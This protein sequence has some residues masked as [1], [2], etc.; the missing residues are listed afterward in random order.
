MKKLTLRSGQ[1]AQR[2]FGL[3]KVMKKVIVTGASGFVG[4][5]VLEELTSFNYEICALYNSKK[6][7]IDGD[8]KKITWKKFNIN[9]IESFESLSKSYEVVIHLI[10]II[11]EIPK[12]NITH[13]NIVAEGTKKIIYG[14]EKNQLKKIV[15]VS[16]AGTR[17][18]ASSKYH[19]AKWE[20][21]QAIQKSS[22][23]WTIFR[24]SLIFPNKNIIKKSDN[25]FVANIVKQ[26]TISPFILLPGKGQSLCQPL[27]VKDLSQ[28]I[29]ASIE[30]N[31]CRI[32]DAGGPS[33]KSYLQIFTEIKH[34]Y[35]PWRP[36]IK[37][38]LRIVNFI[39]KH[40]LEKLNPPP[41]TRDQLLMLNE[42]NLAEP[43][44]KYSYFKKS[45]LTDWEEIISK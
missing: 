21:E 26:F 25:N 15:Y 17:E 13:K 33:K 10:G 31:D 5:A 41:L 28:A 37:C 22:L 24:P 42:D 3:S 4:K 19:R 1:S 34:R 11:S 40:F 35:L 30:D 7:T 14:A 45:K 8:N 27:S 9:D 38:P 29:V 44:S 16:A 39:A 23:A 43:L 6:E 20:A 36:I 18:N 12:K 32:I 2:L